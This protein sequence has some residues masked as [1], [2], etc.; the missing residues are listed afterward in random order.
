MDCNTQEK[1]AG[2]RW[3]ILNKDPDNMVRTIHQMK[4]VNLG[5]LERPEKTDA[6]SCSS[7]R[8]PGADVF[9]MAVFAWKE[10]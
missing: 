2:G 1:I 7:G 3:G 6:E 4:R 8:N 10:D 9:E 5:Y